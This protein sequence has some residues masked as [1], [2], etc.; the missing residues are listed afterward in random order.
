ME[1]DSFQC[2]FGFFSGEFL[3]TPSHGGRPPPPEQSGGPWD[4]YPRPHMEGDQP[5]LTGCCIC[6]ISTHAL[7]WRA[8]HGCNYISKGT[9]NFYPRPHM[10]GDQ[11]ART[12]KQQCAAFLP[13]PSHG[14]R[15]LHGSRASLSHDFYPRPHMEGDTFPQRTHPG[16]FYFYPRPHMEGDLSGNNNICHLPDFYPRPHME[17]DAAADMLGYHLRISTHAL[18]WR[19]T[20]NMLK[21]RR[22]FQQL[23]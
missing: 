5:D 11:R 14:G 9:K 20:A 16:I 3:P 22:A 1:G 18:T 21:C 6:A 4:F 23:I 12:V 8:T 2:G 19:A 10:E 13:T 17:G 7:T 15:L